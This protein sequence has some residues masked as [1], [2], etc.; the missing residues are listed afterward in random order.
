MFVK[1]QEFERSEMNSIRT[2]MSTGEGVV[3]SPD[4]SS[5]DERCLASFSPAAI[6][7]RG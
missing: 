5:S 7:V 2:K 6:N 4:E 3:T 1:N